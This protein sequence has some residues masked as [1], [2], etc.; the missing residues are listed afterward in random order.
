MALGSAA[1]SGGC[2]NHPPSDI[3]AQSLSG[4]GKWG[5]CPS[6]GSESSQ[7][8]RN[9]VWSFAYF[10]SKKS[11][12]WSDFWTREWTGEGG[13]SVCLLTQQGRVVE[14][15]CVNV[16]LSFFCGKTYVLWVILRT[17]DCIV[18]PR[19]HWHGQIGCNEWCI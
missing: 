2:Q 14:Q 8:V 16:L 5:W 7:L 11:V 13:L 17:L 3:F 12:I 9:V 19:F 6:I 1:P 18:V 4:K 10:W 15:V